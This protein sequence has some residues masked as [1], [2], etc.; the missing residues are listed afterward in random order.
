[1]N[2]LFLYDNNITYISES[3]F[4]G[5]PKINSLSIMNNPRM[6]ISYDA[7]YGFSA[8]SAM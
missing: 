3:A 7:F 4:S 2:E 8:L 5:A 6:T 1:M